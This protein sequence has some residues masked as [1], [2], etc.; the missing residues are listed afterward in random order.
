[1]PQMPPP[2]G[3]A[4]VSNVSMLQV[5]R[6]CYGILGMPETRSGHTKLVFVRVVGYEA[7]LLICCDGYEVRLQFE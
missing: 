3:Y 7:L 1:M 2:L 6:P 5:T 4:P